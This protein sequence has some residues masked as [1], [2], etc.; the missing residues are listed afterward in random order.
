M[1]RDLGG[2]VAI[3]GL[4]R[5][6]LARR[7]VAEGATVVLVGADPEVAGALLAELEDVAA[8]KG[9]GRVAYFNFEAPPPEPPGG[10]WSG[11][12]ESELDALVELVA[13]MWPAR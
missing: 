12:T 4:D 9:G 10:P 3:V 11:P 6:D 1:G 8:D 2:R 7:L 5:A 13:E